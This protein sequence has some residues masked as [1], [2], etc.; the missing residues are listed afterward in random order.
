MF[1]KEHPVPQ[2]SKTQVNASMSE[3]FIAFADTLKDNGQDPKE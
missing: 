3:K 1:G 2:N